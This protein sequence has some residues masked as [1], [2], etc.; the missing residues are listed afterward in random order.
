MFEQWPINVATS[1]LACNDGGEQRNLGAVGL[2]MWR[3]L[4]DFT[5]IISIMLYVHYNDCCDPTVSSARV[6]YN[7]LVCRLSMA[8]P[9]NIRQLHKRTIGRIYIPTTKVYKSTHFIF[10]VTKWSYLYLYGYT[11][12]VNSCNLKIKRFTHATSGQT[13]MLNSAIC[14]MRRLVHTS[15]SYTDV[16]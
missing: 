8:E 4:V 16:C 2:R 12:H 6:H 5:N 9:V 14:L 11:A 7:L 3:H 13:I 1:L 15:S 10:G